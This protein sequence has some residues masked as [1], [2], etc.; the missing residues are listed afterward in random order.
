MEKNLKI[1]VVESDPTLSRRFQEILEHLGYHFSILAPPAGGIEELHEIAPHLTILGPTLDREY[2]LRYT[3]KLKIINAHMPILI[4]DEEDPISM[5]FEGI[6]PLPAEPDLD[7]ITEAIR[8]AL[9]YKAECEMRPDYPVIIGQSR[10]IQEIREKV[11][12]VADKDITVLI[13]G[14]SGTGKELIARTIHYYSCRCKGPLVKINC[15][16]LP[17]EL[18]ESEVFGFQR[19]AFTGAYKDKPGRIEL[20]EGGTLFIDEIG[21]LSLPLQ[22]KFL[23]ALEDKAFS[24]LG[25]TEEKVIDT[26]VVAATN[27][28]LGKKVR[29]GTFRKDLFYRLNIVNIEAPPLRE[30]RDDIPILIE[31]FSNK[32]CFEYKKET[33]DISPETLNHLMG[34]SWPGNIRELENMVRRAIVVRDWDFVYGELKSEPRDLEQQGM[35][36]S[37][38]S[39]RD[40]FGDQRFEEFFKD[41]D[42][43]LKTISNAYTAKAERKAIL[44]ALERTGWN[45]NKA[46]RLLQVSY[47]TLLNH[48]NELDLRPSG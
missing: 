6:H 41:N 11:R 39:E 10:P 37:D 42:Y 34:Y 21:D 27:S 15:G 16:A 28:N 3:H 32:Y 47:K 44:K 26:R 19:G 17:D 46:A 33:Q 35:E 12:K 5:P 29:E 30:R 4:S 20:S 45:R 14:E 25:D 7:Q 43:S 1:L 23:Q 31:Y 38:S 40:F 2:L 8:T 36:P 9:S 24:R 18:L 48:I 13:T 22:V